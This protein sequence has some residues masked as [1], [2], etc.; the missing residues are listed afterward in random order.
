MS[1]PS[2]ALTINPS[3]MP[4]VAY[5][6]AAAA[7]MLRA[8]RL[9]R[10]SPTQPEVAVLAAAA[11]LAL[12][13]FGPTAAKQLKS[14]TMAIQAAKTRGAAGAAPRERAWL[15]AIGIKMTGQLAGLAWMAGARGGRG[16]LKGGALMM[17]GNLCFWIA[18]AGAARHSEIGEHAPVPPKLVRVI[19][20]ADAALFITLLV[21]AVGDPGSLARIISSAAFAIGAMAGVLEN[22]PKFVKGLPGTL[23][24]I[25]APTPSASAGDAAASPQAP[26]EE[27]K[28][29]E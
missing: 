15:W 26:V 22:I 4:A 10:A 28:V 5:T 7:L 13:D 23:I 18:G 27:D 2:L 24:G 20:A 3:V 21:G 8:A 19:F 6:S 17:A 14:A 9:S 16:I 12:I 29:A 1:T 11:L 25:S